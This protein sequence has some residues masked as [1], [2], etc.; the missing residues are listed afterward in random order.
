MIKNEKIFENLK[1]ML[2]FLGVLCLIVFYF[3]YYKTSKFGNN[4]INKNEEEIIEYILKQVKTYTAN[5]NVIV[6]S[7][8]TEI[9]YKIKQEV[10]DGKSI[11]EV[12]YPEN[13]KGIKIALEGNCLTIS[14]TELNLEK[15]Y[16]SYEPFLNN[17]LFLNVFIEDYKKNI[18]NSYVLEDEIILETKIE[19]N[20]NTYAQYKELHIDKKS[21]KIKELIVKDNN[22]KTRIN[23][24]YNDIEIK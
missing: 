4:I 23:I 22:K 12:L 17:A 9:E 21:N 7:N 2:L 15:I 13:V 16:E 20:T 6:Y 10:S 18:S 3:F 1:K 8:K 19:H 5:M 14:N 11:Q 24:K